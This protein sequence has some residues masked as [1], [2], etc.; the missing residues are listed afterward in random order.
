MEEV[1]EKLVMTLGS[2]TSQRLVPIVGGIIGGTVNYLF[3]KGVAKTLLIAK[4]SD[5]ASLSI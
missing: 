2:K 5:S 3:I 4:E 1:A